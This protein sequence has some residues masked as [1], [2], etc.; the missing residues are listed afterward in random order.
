[1]Q[2]LFEQCFDLLS[3][4]SRA[5]SGESLSKNVEY[6]LTALLVALVDEGSAL[7]TEVI[8][9]ILAQFLR[10]DIGS[11]IRLSGNSKKISQIDEKQTTLLL[12]EAPP[13][14]NM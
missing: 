14:Y 13:A 12:K 8:E 5:D 10:A 1:M 2:T 6:R 4:T 7:P 3:G 11:L 9:V